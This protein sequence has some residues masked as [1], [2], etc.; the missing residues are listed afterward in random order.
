MYST[1]PAFV[2]GFHGCDRSVGERVLSGKTSLKTSENNYDWLGHGVYFWEHNPQRALEYA[3][4]LAANP[5]RAKTPITDPFV[6][7]AVIDLGR[8]LN[9]L[10]SESLHVLAGAYEALRESFESADTDMPVNSEP[11][12]GGYHLLRHLDCA[13]VEYLHEFEE[14]AGREPLDSVRGVFFEG[15]SLYPGA[16]F[17]EKNHIQVCVRNPNC[18][19][20]YFRVRTPDNDW[21]VP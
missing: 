5:G 21:P 11:D 8:C 2:L 14:Q 3:Q 20:G 10:E 17:K 9:L 16:G 4:H 1:L 15:A 13:V 7:G 6:L 18:I 19:K 12:A